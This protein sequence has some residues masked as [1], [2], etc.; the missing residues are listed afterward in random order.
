M[1]VVKKVTI[2]DR[3]RGGKSLPR[4]GMCPWWVPPPPSSA[5]YVKPIYDNMRTS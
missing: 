1:K 5:A 3:L 2:P 4:G